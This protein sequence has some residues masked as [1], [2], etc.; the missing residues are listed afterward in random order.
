MGGSP[1]EYF[2]GIWDAA[3]LPGL[4]AK[5]RGGDVVGITSETFFA[6]VVFF[7]ERWCLAGGW[8]GGLSLQG[9]EGS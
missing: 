9:K 4:G 2:Y 1:L 5:V 6:A 3:C 8:V 7:R